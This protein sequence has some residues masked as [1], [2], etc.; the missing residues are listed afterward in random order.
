MLAQAGDDLVVAA[1]RCP[2]PRH[3]DKIPG[4]QIIE[5]AESFTSKAFQSVACYR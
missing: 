1:A 5:L 2:R 4:G 3:Y